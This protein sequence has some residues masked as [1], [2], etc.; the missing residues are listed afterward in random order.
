MSK[1]KQYTITL[2]AKGKILEDLHYG[3]YAR[4]WWEPRKRSY[5]KNPFPNTHPPQFQD[6]GRYLQKSNI[7]ER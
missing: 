5:T 4:Y 3:M 6:P 2:L 1:K 7:K